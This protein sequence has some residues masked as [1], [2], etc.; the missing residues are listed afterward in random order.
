MAVCANYDEFSPD[1]FFTVAR[2][3]SR[4]WLKCPALER[5]NSTTDGVMD[6]TAHAPRAP[7]DVVAL[8][9]FFDTL[10]FCGGILLLANRLTRKLWP[11][12]SADSILSART[13][14]PAMAPG[15]DS[16]TTVQQPEHG[17]PVTRRMRF[18]VT[19]HSEWQAGSSNQSD[20]SFLTSKCLHR[21]RVC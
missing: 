15:L 6:L 20:P 7:T 12:F 13:V 18:R 19:R 21:H 3:S 16:P 17:N 11:G 4:R 2:N 5:A 10:L 1:D 8:N 9:F 14:E